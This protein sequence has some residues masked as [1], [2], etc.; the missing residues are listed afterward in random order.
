MPDEMAEITLSKYKGEDALKT[1]Y[2]ALSK[3]MDGNQQPIRRR[4]F[5]FTLTFQ[6]YLRLHP[7]RRK[8]NRKTTRLFVIF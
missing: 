4:A 8:A 7:Y 6:V 5:R 1:K 2:F 3:A